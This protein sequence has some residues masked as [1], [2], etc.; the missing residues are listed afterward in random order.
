MKLNKVGWGFPIDEA[1]E[2]EG[3]NEGDIE[4]FLNNPL[5]SIAKESAQNSLDARRDEKKPV[6]LEFQS[7]YIPKEDFPDRQNFDK[8]LDNQIKFWGKLEKDKKA[9][10][11]FKKAKEVL[12]SKKILCLRI[13]DFNTTGLSGSTTE[14][15]PFTG[16]KKLVKS[17]GVSN[18]PS[19]SGG[20]FGLGK[21]ASFA[22]SYLRTVLYNT[23]DSKRN[24]A[25]QGVAHLATYKDGEDKHFRRKGYYGNFENFS[26][27]RNKLVFDSGFVRKEFGTD[28]YIL[29]FNNSDENW[30]D[31][32][33]C[34]ILES[35]LLAIYNGDLIFKFNEYVLD[36]KSLSETIEK[37]RSLDYSELL[38]DTIFDYY[39]ILAGNIISKEYF[40]TI[41]EKNDVLLKLSLGPGLTNKIAMNRGNGMKIFDKSRG[42]GIEDCAGV[43]TL[44]RN[45][46]NEYFRRLEN[47]EHSKWFPNR[48]GNRQDAENKIKLLT[49]QINESIEKMSN[50][51]RP[52]SL[53]PEGIGEFLPD[54]LENDPAKRKKIEDLGWEIQMG[55]LI[56]SKNKKRQ[57][58]TL[59]NGFGGGP[60]G[61]SG[62]GGGRYGSGK[63]EN[64]EIKSKNIIETN[65]IHAFY[66]KGGIYQLVFSIPEE[67][68]RLNAE[69]LISGE[70]DTEIP[71]IEKAELVEKE[72]K[73]DLKFEENKIFIENVE[74]NK[75]VFIEFKL[76][77][78]ERWTLEVELYEN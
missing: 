71:W 3:I 10:N 7:F 18:N 44:K 61:G 23:M 31:K 65:S 42:R 57:Q 20:S 55:K 33:I 21:H 69:I 26:N 77:E 66:K 78:S 52:E 50:E 63:G 45:G 46:V 75:K 14:E 13:S 36:K 43:L 29:G 68:E 30:K 11:F 17:T 32:I 56:E 47:P 54:D 41:I 73:R 38:N 34:S 25:H 37:Y 67:S 22:C 40:I 19:G 64:P 28:V 24:E 12:N 51:E 1:K 2:I 4:N 70:S 6:V 48:G 9:E 74:K 39:D 16:W 35:F 8:I 27:I 53:D 59:K 60:S 49:Q 58:V 76:K 15:E 72:S 62:R 5:L